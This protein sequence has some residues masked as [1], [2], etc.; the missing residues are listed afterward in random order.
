MSSVS[1]KPF[2]A[3]SKVPLQENKLIFI[4]G[5]TTLLVV[6]NVTMFN[7]AL[8]FILQDFSL[9]SST[10]SWLVSGYSIMFAL[11]TL[12]FGRLSDFFPISNLVFFGI[13]LLATASIIGFF[14]T[15]FFLLLGARILQATGAGGFIGLGMIMAGRYIPLSRRGKAMAIIVSAASLAF[16]LGPVFGGVITQYLGWNYLFAV[17]GISVLSIPFLQKH[18]PKEDIQRGHFDLYGAILTG[19]SV[20]GMLLFLS[21]FS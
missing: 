5:F 4:W 20:T 10:A 9:S 19:L 16:G 2:Q 12:I 3:E 11:S 6:M 21:T 1:V 13:C 15:H 17:T 14:S 18:L 7:V 8:P